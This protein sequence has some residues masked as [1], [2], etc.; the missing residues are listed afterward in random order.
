M[1]AGSGKCTW[2]SALLLSLPVFGA[3]AADRYSR[4]FVTH[5]Q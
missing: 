1:L 5:C 4:V 2:I 3:G